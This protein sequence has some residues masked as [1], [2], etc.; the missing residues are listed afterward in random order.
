MLRSVPWTL[1][2]IC[3]TRREE[4]REDFWTRRSQSTL[5]SY[6]A[7]THRR[8][9]AQWSSSISEVNSPRNLHPLTRFHLDSKFTNRVG[10]GGCG[11]WPEVDTYESVHLGNKWTLWSEQSL[12]ESRRD[13][14]GRWE[15]SAGSSNRLC[16]RAHRLRGW[17]WRTA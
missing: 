8:F 2:I 9:K 12:R 10:V 11:R 5:A 4:T 13:D 7:W 17:R 15:R 14:D 3:S 16:S 1:P 6:C